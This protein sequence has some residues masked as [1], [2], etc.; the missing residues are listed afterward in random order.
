MNKIVRHALDVQTAFSSRLTL[1]ST[2]E[3][4]HD[5][6]S[7]SATGAQA[8]SPVEGIGIQEQARSR[9][10][11]RKLL[12]PLAVAMYRSLKPLIRP[13]ATR[14]RRYLIDGMV[15]QNRQD[16]QDASAAAVRQIQA[17]LQ[18]A[19]AAATR[20]I[21]HDV[22]ANVQRTRLDLLADMAFVSQQIQR[23]I[24]RAEGTNRS[25]ATLAPRLDRIETYSAA[26]ARRVAVN[27]GAGEILVKT[28]V[29]FVLCAESDHALLACLLD[30]GE[31]ERGTRQLIQRY[32]KPG[33]CYIDVGANV[34]LHTLA[35]AQSLQGHGKIHAVEP[36]G[37]TAHM[38]EKT[39]WMNGYADI[40]SI[41]QAAASN[42]TGRQKL[43]IGATS[44]HHSLFK[45]PPSPD[46]NQAPVDVDLITLDGLIAPDQHVNLLKIDAEGAELDVVEGAASLIAHNP[47]IALIVEFGPLH[48]R[49]TETSP[50]QWLAPFSQLGLDYRIINPDSGQLEHGSLEALENVASINL[51]FARPGSAAWHR[52]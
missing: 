44:G 28:G 9:F 22:V 19:L 50:T 8:P 2:Q 21:Q 12:R 45:L 31:L 5:S 1:W 38:L 17:D 6:V 35:A 14:A 30:T 15:Q 13:V 40:T 41:H 42:T 11:F 34:G 20:T 18:V 43:F 7:P 33:D 37:P 36:F 47:D 25:D 49:R 3:R 46:H 16:I 39:V 51:F 4:K 48:L 27:C 26:T 24:Q 23:E 32:L 10:S 52:L 29:G